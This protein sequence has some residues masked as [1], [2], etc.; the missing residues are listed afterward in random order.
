MKYLDID[1]WERKQHFEFFMNFHDPHFAV[2]IPFDVTRAYAFS[3]EKGLSFFGVYLH[4][5][6]KAIN[7]VENFRYRITPDHKVVVHDV[8]H[9]SPTI[10]RPDHTFG[11]SYIDFSEDLST[12]LKHLSAEKERILNSKNLF[13]EEERGEDCIYCSALPW[14][15]FTG[16]KE[17]HMALAKESVPKLAFGKVKEEGD[18]L[19]MNVAVNV[20]H[21][22]V[23][24]YHVGLFSD[25]FQYYLDESI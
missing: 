20:N 21:A 23:D 19:I 16:H 2:T 10:A 4:A 1:T 24:G 11:F 6:M 7:Q 3:K 17:P 14:F 18:K 5:C 13:P 12:F 25:R 22:L 8:I 9:A 15:D